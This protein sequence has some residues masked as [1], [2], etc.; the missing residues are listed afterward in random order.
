MPFGMEFA[1]LGTVV[2]SLV[3]L[4]IC[5]VLAVINPSS[6]R[7]MLRVPP[8]SVPKVIALPPTAGMIPTNPW[9]VALMPPVI[10]ASCPRRITVPP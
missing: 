2:P 8:G 6:D 3:R 5:T 10:V 9:L 7:R 1:A 4:P